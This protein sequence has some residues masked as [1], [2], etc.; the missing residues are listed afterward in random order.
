[1]SVHQAFY[2]DGALQINKA[3]IAHV[4]SL[5]LDFKNKTVLETGC[6]GKGDFTKYLTN[7]GAQV[8]LNDARIENITTLLQ[9]TGYN[10]P[11]NTWDLDGDNKFD[12]I[13]C[14]GTLYHLKNPG[15]ALKNLSD[16]CTDFMIL[17]TCTSGD[18]SDEIN[19]VSESGQNQA[20]NNTGCRPG[21]GFIYKKL[22]ESF[23]HVY[24]CKTQP[25]HGDYPL[26]WPCYS[27]G[28]LKR[29]VFIASRTSIVNDN[30]VEDVLVQEYN[31]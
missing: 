6:G 5:G 18:D 1:M 25:N 26:K 14:Y 11:Y 24:L 7:Q 31:C 16:I 9:E 22:K 3:R 30:L 13:F 2:Y 4:D 23:N 20:Y 21:R 29:C 8:T 15:E 12:V 19:L 17:S 10:L 27:P 28:Q